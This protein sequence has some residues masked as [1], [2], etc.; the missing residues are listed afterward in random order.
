MLDTS[1]TDLCRLAEKTYCDAWNI[2]S[3]FFYD[4]DYYVWM[5]NKVSP[6]NTVL[7]IGCGT[8]Y[9]TLSLV[10]KGHA[11]ISIEK[12]H[13]CIVKA[14]ELLKENNYFESVQFVEGDL[15]DQGIDICVKLCP[16]IDVLVCWNPGPGVTRKDDII[17]AYYSDLV[18]YGLDKQQIYQNTESSYTE[19]LLYRACVIAK[20][21]RIPIHIIDRIQS[22]YTDKAYY[23]TL[24]STV[25]YS[26]IDFDILAAK[27]I[28]RGGVPLI[29][30]G[31]KQTDTIIPI[32]FLSILMK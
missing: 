18:K 10:E 9:S 17:K 25:G 30:N 14:K 1:K 31:I 13:E 21:L 15:I 23:N 26:H 20:A 2:S 28:S 3:K 27:S 16:N 7:E 24:A 12:N 6:F 29:E 19:L 11:V 4:N 32:C 5:C 8:G 22:P